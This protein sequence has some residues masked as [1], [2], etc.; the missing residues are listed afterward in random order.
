VKVITNCLKTMLETF[1][2][3]LHCVDICFIAD[4]TLERLPTSV[5]L[6][7]TRIGG[8]DLNKSRMRAALKALLALAASPQGFTVSQFASQVR[9]LI[10]PSEQVY[11]PRRAAHDLKKMRAKALIAKIGSSR[12]YQPLPQGLKAIAALLVLREKVI[13]PLLAGVTTPRRGRKPKDWSRID[14]HYETLRL[15]MRA[16]FQELRIAA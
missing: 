11:G 15:N 3:H 12:H 1:L 13:Q 10:G 14:Q 5:Q 4:D 9:A 6:G 7:K 16:L 8:I 2:N